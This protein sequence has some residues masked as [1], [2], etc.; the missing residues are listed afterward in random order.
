MIG[1][2]QDITERRRL[3]EE[4]DRLLDEERRAGAFR[5]AFVDVISHEL[6]TP[7]TTILGLT[8]ILARPG[9]ADDEASRT[10]LLEDIR[11]ES[12][13][14]HRL[15]E[16][17]LVLSRVERGVSRS[18]PSRSSRGAC[19]SGSSPTRPRELPSITVETELEPDLPIV[20]GEDDLRRADRAEHARATRRSTRRSARTCRRC[21]ARRR[22]GTSR[23][24]SLDDGPGHPGG[25]RSS[26]SSSS[27][28]ATPTSARLGRR[29]RDRAVRLRQPRRGDGRPDLGRAPPEGGSE[30]G[31]TLRVIE[32]DD[33][34]TPPRAIRDG[35]AADRR[36]RWGRARRRPRR[37]R[38]ALTRGRRRRL[39]PTSPRRAQRRAGRPSRGRCRGRG[40]PSRP[41][42]AGSA[43]Q[44]AS[45]DQRRR[46]DV[47]RVDLEQRAQVLARAAPA[48]AVRAQ[49]DVVSRAASGRP[50]RAGPSSSRWRPRSG[51][52]RAAGPG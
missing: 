43:P 44:R 1:T 24:A 45:A 7:I 39:R 23:S 26:G 38:P 8:Q 11:S 31:F 3:E 27:S 34:P 41:S 6:R 13:R 19:W 42:T 52:R 50:C 35:G 9:R 10:A 5:E 12:E 47:R 22:T 16:D 14:L 15:V 51:R 17:L 25:R 20:A 2:G 18:R 4:R 36:A 40:P 37:V 46:R 21:G 28:T 30:F 49:R 48:E 29:L 32:P 33:E